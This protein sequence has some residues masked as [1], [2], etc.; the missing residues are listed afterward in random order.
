MIVKVLL[1]FIGGG[2]GSVLRFGIAGLCTSGI[3]S[4]TVTIP[5]GTLV[6]NLLGC[7]LIGVLAALFVS[8]QIEPVAESMNESARLFLMVGLLGGFTTFS[9]FGL[10]SV[11][12]MQ[13]KKWLLLMI[14]VM[15]SNIGGITLACL[16]LRIAG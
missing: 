12:L 14:Y 3:T 7:F 4:E 1:I 10:E 15:V 16:G 8:E 6:V 11:E 9:T 13:Q 2:I 5:V